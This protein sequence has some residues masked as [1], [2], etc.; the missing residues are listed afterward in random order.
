VKLG[1]KKKQ[2]FC[3]GV[4]F[5]LKNKCVSNNQATEI[6]LLTYSEISDA[7]PLDS[8]ATALLKHTSYDTI[9]IYL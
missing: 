6:K 4:E 7:E 9:K 3:I 2:I 5:G 8:S 1:R